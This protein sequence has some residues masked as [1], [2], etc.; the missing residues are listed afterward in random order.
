MSL[1]FF[2]PLLKL[3]AFLILFFLLPLLAFLVFLQIF[4]LPSSPFLPP[5]LLFPPLFYII[6]IWLPF[7]FH[8]PFLL[9]CL[10]SFLSSIVSSNI[11]ETS[12][13][14]SFLP[15]FS[16]P[17]SSS[18]CL[19]SCFVRPSVLPSSRVGIVKNNLQYVS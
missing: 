2:I 4:E 5:T 11:Y 14:P 7:M 9:F 15:I 8:L 10:S 17:P 1:V 16:I 18:H 13:L 19:Y 3:C 12:S 6:F